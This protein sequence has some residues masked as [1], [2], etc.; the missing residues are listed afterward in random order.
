MTQRQNPA[1]W[2]WFDEARFGLFIHWG[3]TSQWGRGEQVMIR[4]LLDQEQFAARACSWNPQ[5][6]D[7]AEWASLA[8]KAGMRY[9]VF[10]ARHHDGF[11]LWNSRY[12]D[13]SSAAQVAGR[14]FVAEFVSAFRAEGLRVGLYYSWSDWRIPAFFAGP[15]ENPREWGE[16]LDYVHGQIR[17]LV[18]NYGKIDLLWLD[19]VWPHSAAVWRSA[20]LVES[21]RALQPEILINNRLGYAS[22]FD[23]SRPGMDLDA[24]LNEGLAGDFG[25]PEH[26]ITPDPQRL[27]ESCQTSTWRLWGNCPGERWRP[28]DLWLDYLCEGHRQ[29]RPGATAVPLVDTP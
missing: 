13:Y 21:V 29:P 10:V 9:A 7:A 28:T 3:S 24:L 12:T 27:W 11:T 19:G 20:E 4:E 22:G 17:E 23:T 18:T 15:E 1:K 14:D 6:F 26:H 25:T 5:R 16:Y 2:Q 8:R